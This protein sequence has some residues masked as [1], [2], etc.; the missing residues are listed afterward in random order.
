MAHTAQRYLQQDLQLLAL[1]GK[2]LRAQLD[3]LVLEL[4][5]AYL[6]R[7]DRVRVLL[8]QC[9]LL[10]FAGL[11]EGGRSGLG[12]TKKAYV[13]YCFTVLCQVPLEGVLAVQQAICKF[14]S[15]LP[16]SSSCTRN[17]TGKIERELLAFAGIA[18]GGRRGLIR[19]KRVCVAL[20]CRALHSSLTTSEM[21]LPCQ[22]RS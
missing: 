22:R 20:L 1:A 3:L 9:E 11:A 14:W 6:R 15:S 10:A 5:H 8:E 19:Q 18:E 21:R 17:T 2:Q 13:K 7:E 16:Y 12:K 4:L